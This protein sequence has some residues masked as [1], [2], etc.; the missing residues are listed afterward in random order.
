MGLFTKL[1]S[2]GQDKIVKQYWKDV[3]KIN[4]LEPKYQA[5]SD[6]EIIE[7]AQEMREK[8]FYASCWSSGR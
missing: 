4:A 1:L 3:E 8:F 2:A 6:E 5:M 7:K